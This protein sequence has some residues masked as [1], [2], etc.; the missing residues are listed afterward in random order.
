MDRASDYG[1]EGWEF[2]SLR[3]RQLKIPSHREGI[4]FCVKSVDG[5]F[6]HRSKRGSCLRAI[7][8]NIR[9][10]PRSFKALSTII[11]IC[12][13]VQSGLKNFP[14]PKH[15][16]HHFSLLPPSLFVPRQ[17]PAFSVSSGIPQLWHC[18]VIDT[19]PVFKIL[20]V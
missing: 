19:G 5:Y 14:F 18:F 20:V 11:C 6:F 12:S 8:R 7:Q 15:K 1:S 9:L 16:L 10:D 3:A 17:S 13:M 4:L 2:K